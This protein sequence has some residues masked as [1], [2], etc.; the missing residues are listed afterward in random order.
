MSKVTCGLTTKRLG[1]VQT[2]TLTSSLRLL[3]LLLM[4]CSSWALP[5]PP[6]ITRS[7]DCLPSS[8]QTRGQYSV[9]SN[10]PQLHVARYGW[11]FLSWDYLYLYLYFNDI[12]R[13]YC[14]IGRNVSLLWVWQVE[15]EDWTECLVCSQTVRLHQCRRR[16]SAWSRS[17]SR[18]APV[19]DCC[20]SSDT[21]DIE[22][23]RIPLCKTTDHYVQGSVGRTF[24]FCTQ[25]I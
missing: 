11:V 16:R 12:T 22:T 18:Q 2:P 9:A 25:Y 8:M 3:L 4:A 7:P 19:V 20:S 15:A 24:R 23:R 13:Y 14:I 21:F 6:L 1:S 17:C 10:P 5:C